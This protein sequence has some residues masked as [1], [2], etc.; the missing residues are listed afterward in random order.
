MKPLLRFVLSL[1][2]SCA[3]LFAQ[4]T[5]S[6]VAGN[7]T[8][9]S[10]TGDGGPA[11]SAGLGFPAGVAAD[12]FGNVYIADTASKR[13]RKVT[14]STG[15]IA[16]YAGGG[17][18]GNIAEGGAAISAGF[19]FPANSHI[20]LAVDTDGNLYIADSGTNRVRKVSTAGMITTVAGAGGLGDPGFSGDGG[21]ATAAK[22]QAPT[23]V[24]LDSR[25]NIYIADT[26]NGR[27]RKVDTS[28][29]I[30]TVVGRGNGSVTGDGGQ[31]LN[32]QL[33]NPA[34][35][36]V[37][38]Q[39]NI[40]IADFGNNSIRKVD[41]NGV[42]N[43]ILRGGFGRCNATPVT[44]ARADIGRAVGI[45]IDA[46][47][48]LY[49][50][51]ESADCVLMAE[52][53]GTVSTVAGG[54]SKMPPDKIP[55]TDALL[56][57]IWSVNVDAAGNLYV[58]NSLGYVHKV[59]PRATPPSALPVI[60]SVVNGASFQAGIAPNSWVTV[61]GTNLSSQTDVWDKAIIAGQLPTALD[62]IGVTIG[63]RPVY[64]EYISPTQINVLTPP[65]L[66]TGVLPVVV[67]T[68]AGASTAFSV[69]SSTYMPAF[70]MW[71][72]SQPVATHADFSWAAKAGTFAG[73]TTIPAKPGDA[74][75][76]WGTGMGPTSPAAPIGVQ[77]SGGP[78]S[79]LSLP[80]ITVLATKATVYGGALA[81]G[82]AGLYQLAF[83]VPA[84]FPDGDYPINGTVGGAPFAG[85]ATIT[86]KK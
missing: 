35:V 45:A 74:I 59:T 28:G 46:N 49:I 52:P 38:S 62:N 15:N 34:D 29:M 70:F 43:T 61:R 16:T 71:P 78:Y 33:N 55:A 79:T 39:G 82:Y 53:N 7:G 73:A 81:P 9:F 30:T 26:G 24:A 48:N 83:Q 22:L 47:D 12:G 25:R 14:A 86:V 66:V 10:A 84:D 42:I 11:T 20:G 6:I 51:N 5:I 58:T 50:A 72:N 1:S 13:V 68:P 27:I 17:A 2:V 67:T 57:N 36:A 64:V 75:I 54:G 32:A 4:G 3:A 63:G 19:T 69:T 23:G 31:A 60:T 80:T 77:V 56:G 44:A 8:I 41:K 37:D 18:P 85:T 65:D 21:P 76:L 40:Y